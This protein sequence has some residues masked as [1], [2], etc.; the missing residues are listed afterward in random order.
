MSEPQLCLLVQ[1][2]CI[3]FICEGSKVQ[4][5]FQEV[6]SRACKQPSVSDRGRNAFSLYPHHCKD[7]TSL[8]NSP[9]SVVILLDKSG[10]D[11]GA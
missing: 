3:S 5:L 2:M 7:D 6:Q 4:V 8:N 11:L 1:V 9:N 10:Y